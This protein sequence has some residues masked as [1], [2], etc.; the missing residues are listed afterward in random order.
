MALE[1]ECH[2]THRVVEP[3]EVTMSPLPCLQ[4]RELNLVAHDPLVQYLQERYPGEQLLPADPKVRAQIRQI[5]SLIRDDEED[6][7]DSLSLILGPRLGYIAGEEFTLA[8][9]YAG[10][11]IH[12]MADRYYDLP[13]N[14]QDYYQRLAGRKAFKEATDD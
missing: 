10:V 12:R 7:I 1:K 2:L 9:V 6:F 8:D 14:V 11:R 5:C 13:E 4:D 3:Y